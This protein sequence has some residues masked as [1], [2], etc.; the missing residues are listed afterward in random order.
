MLIEHRVTG[1]HLVDGAERVQ[2]S[3]YSAI[4]A[5]RWC[6]AGPAAAEAGWVAVERLVQL[7]I[8]PGVAGLIV[9]QRST[10]AT[11]S[12]NCATVRPGLEAT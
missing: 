6:P 3:A 12:R 1:A 7:V 8:P 11:A 9:G 10:T 5:S 2:V 4:R